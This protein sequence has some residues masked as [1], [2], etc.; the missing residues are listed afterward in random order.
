MYSKGIFKYKIDELE[1]NILSCLLQK[2]ELMEKVILEDKY[3]VK[4]KKLWFFMKAFYSKFKNFDI[5]LMYSVVKDKYRFL[6]YITWLLDVEPCPSNFEK[7]QQQ[8]I[9][10]YKENEKEK[11]LIE[12]I[13][14]IS[15]DLL[16]RNI[17]TTEF[18]Q[19]ID[20]IFEKM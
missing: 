10:L 15:N 3:F 1:I 19:K 12:K 8:L 11:K 9:Y 13:Y 14:A 20:N 17:T 6:D 5:S 7:Y 2:P 16:V 18:K 4:T